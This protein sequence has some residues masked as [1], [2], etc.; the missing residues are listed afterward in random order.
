VKY[1]ADFG[2]PFTIR[3]NPENG[4]EYEGIIVKHGYNLSGDSIV[5]DNLQWQ[6]T[7]FSRKLFNDKHE[8]TI[9]AECMNGDIEIEGLF[10]EK[11]TYVPESDE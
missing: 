8:F 5:H 11:G 3:M 9:P 1:Q 4:F 6:C 10:I 7:R 2:K